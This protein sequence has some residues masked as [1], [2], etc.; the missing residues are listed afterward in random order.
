[1]HPKSGK[2][3]E[4]LRLVPGAVFREEDL[5]TSTSGDWEPCPMD[6]SEG[7]ELK[8]TPAIWIRPGNLSEPAR[9]LLAVLSDP[10]AFYSCAIESTR[11]TVA[12]P[13]PHWNHDG[14]WD[15]PIILHPECLQELVDVGYLKFGEHPIKNWE[16]DY[17][18]CRPE[19]TNK[20]YTVTEIGKRKGEE[21][22]T[23]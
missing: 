21:L 14:R 6:V 23:T 20:A 19:G 3:V 16:S 12:A 15:L 7:V 13:A 5:Y 8:Q 17:A 9:T 4:G 1:M 2:I 18:V 11:G 22:R 10:K